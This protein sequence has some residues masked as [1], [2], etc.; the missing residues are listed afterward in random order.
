MR[1]PFASKRQRITGGRPTGPCRVVNPSPESG[2]GWDRDIS[3]RGMERLATCPNF[4]VLRL[5]RAYCGAH[6]SSKCA[7]TTESRWQ[8]PPPQKNQSGTDV[9]VF[10]EL[11]FGPLVPDPSLGACAFVRCRLARTLRVH[12][13]G[14]RGPMFRAMRLLVGLVAMVWSSAALAVDPLT[15]GAYELYTSSGLSQPGLVGSYVNQSLA[16]YSISTASL[17]HRARQRVTLSYLRAQDRLRFRPESQMAP[18]L[19]PS[20]PVSRYVSVIRRRYSSSCAEM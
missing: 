1:V 3:N 2:A 15:P 19:R 8:R 7:K 6:P 18:G 20:R 13:A 10:C 5:I 9:R 14:K 16:A 4:T 12:S 17:T 11:V